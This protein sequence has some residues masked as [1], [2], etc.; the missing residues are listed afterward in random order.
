M[1]LK[2][3][4]CEKGARQWLG[5]PGIERARNGRLWCACFSGG[6]REPDK[7]NHILLTTSADDGATWSPLEKI[8]D[9]PEGRRAF[10]PTL[11]HD[12][13][14][15]L[16]LIYNIGCVAPYE[17]CF[18][19]M[20][21][22]DSTVSSPEWSEPRKI[23][24]GVSYSFRINKPTVLSTGAW[25]LPVTWSRRPA[26]G[27]FHDEDHLQGVAVSRDQ[28]QTWELH[29]A[30][31]APRWALE[32]MIVELRDGRLWMLIRT[33]AGVLWE[34]FSADGGL[35]WDAARPTSVVNPGSRFFIRRTLSSRLLMINSPYADRRTGMLAS[36][37]EDDG[38][39]FPLTLWL[40]KGDLL[41][42]PDAVE[43]PDG[44][45]Y[46]VYDHDRQGAGEIFL[47]KFT[48]DDFS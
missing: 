2:Q 44:T 45:F 30:C 46:A 24:L 23:E 27:W 26:D 37:S 4:I 13:A 12:P 10:D 6:P 35:N 8:V 11:W 29:G 38:K 21:T 7:D 17:Q 36:L 32:N 47:A 25:L 34:S 18:Y 48:E 31:E 16:W 5:I 42:Y 33:G 9:F 19:A 15:K 3:K 28:G 43:S 20:T 14:G 40:D 39:T 41:S 22:D 1:E